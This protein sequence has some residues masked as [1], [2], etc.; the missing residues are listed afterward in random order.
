MVKGAVQSTGTKLRVSNP[1]ALVLSRHKAFPD[2]QTQPI[3][4]RNKLNG[5]ANG[6]SLIYLFFVIELNGDGPEVSDACV[7]TNKCYE[8]PHPVLTLL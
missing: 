8:D 2:Q 7:R 6:Q 3:S 4:M 1:G 5:T